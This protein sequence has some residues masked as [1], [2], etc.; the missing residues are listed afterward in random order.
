MLGQLSGM[1]P[2]T[3]GILL[4]HGPGHLLMQ[5][6]SLWSNH[7]FIERL[8]EKGMSKAVTDNSH[9]RTLLQHRKLHSFLEG[10]DEQILV[11]ILYSLQH[12]QSELP[13]DDRSDGEDLVA[14]FAEASETLT[15]N[16]P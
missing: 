4:L 5:L 2:Q 1:F 8:P 13:S 7:F 9:L 10:T 16:I 15:D 14:P 11:D 6:Q 12:L 3:P